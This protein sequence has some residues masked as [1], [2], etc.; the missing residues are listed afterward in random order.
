[1]LLR[2]IGLCL[3]AAAFV[4][5]ILDGTRSLSSGTLFVTSL[6]DSLLAIASGKVDSARDFI[7]RHIHPLL[8]DVLTDLFK[9]PA[10]LAFG[11]LGGL[12]IRL[13]RKPASRFGF[14]SR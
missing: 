14:S 10:W 1:M 7:E 13:G 12:I 6:G 9:L 3:L 8:W 5:L 4:F 11:V 2:F